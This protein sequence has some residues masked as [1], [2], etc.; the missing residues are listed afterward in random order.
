MPRPRNV[1]RSCI[2][3]SALL[4][5]GAMAGAPLLSAASAPGS[6]ANP[7]K[8]KAASGTKGYLP[9]TLTVAPG[10]KV[11]FTSVDHLP[12]TATSYKESKGKPVFSNAPSAGTFSIKAPKKAGTY[13][14]FC[15][16]HPYQKG[17]LVV[18]A[19]G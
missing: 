7:V 14:Y 2:A 9:N 6:K 5:T 17:T 12:H 11:W 13:R 3:L 19:K 1:A 10:Q 15:L 8:A 18:R 4:A 16:V